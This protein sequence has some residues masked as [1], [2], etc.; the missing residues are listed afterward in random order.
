MSAAQLVFAAGDPNAAKGL[1]ADRC[2]KCHETP[3]TKPGQ[4][5]EAVEAPSFLSLASDPDRYPPERLRKTLRQPHFPM[6]QFVLSQRDIDNILA[7]IHS[8]RK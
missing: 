4:R 7:Y 5:T 8:L 1:I 3:Y 2:A 6:Q